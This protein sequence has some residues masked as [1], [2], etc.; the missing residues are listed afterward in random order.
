MDTRDRRAICHAAG[1]ALTPKQQDMRQLVLIYIGIITAMSL[2]ASILTVVLQNRIDETGGLRS[3]GLRS[4]LSTAQTVLPMI[5]TLV[6]WVLQIGYTTAALRVA[7]GQD[8]SRDT[9][10]GGLRRF[11]ALLRLQLLQG[12]LY[13]SVGMVSMYAAVYI[14]LLLPVSGPFQEVIMPAIES[15]NIISGTISLD[16]ATVAAASETMRPLIWILVALF[17]LLFIPMHYSHRMT[18]LRLIDHD[19][20]RAL[21]ALLESRALMRRCRLRLLK[22]DLSLWWFYALQL[23]TLLLGYG[24]VLLSYLGITLPIPEMGVYFLFLILALAARAALLYTAMN[25]VSVTYAVFYDA[26]HTEKLAQAEETKRHPPVSIR[27]PWKNPYDQ[28]IENESENEN[29]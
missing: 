12:F 2:G 24:D 14:F 16:A 7:R 8:I 22:L 18:L 4:A 21:G 17:L 27:V 5:Q 6:L 29:P 9:L 1:E 28:E 15:A 11:P 26:L 23:L 3:M 25:R 19:H 20:P 13:S 10:F